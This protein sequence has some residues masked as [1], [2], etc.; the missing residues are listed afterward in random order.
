[1]FL[2]LIY[3]EGITAHTSNNIS[4][5]INTNQVSLLVLASAKLFSILFNCFKY[6][7]TELFKTVYVLFLRRFKIKRLFNFIS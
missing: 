5:K 4:S 2:F 3:N 6:L 1:M 7:W